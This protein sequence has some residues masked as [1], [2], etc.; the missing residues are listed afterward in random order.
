[1]FG[2]WGSNDA[3]TLNLT[4]NAW[5]QLN[6]TGTKPSGR[7]GSSSILYNKQMVMFGGRGSN[8]DFNDVWTLNLTSYAWTQL[9]TTGT[10]PSERYGHSSTLYNGQMVVFG[11]FNGNMNAWT[12]DLTAPT[13]APTTTLAPTT[14]Q[15]PTTK[16][17]QTTT[18]QPTTEID[19][20]TRASFSFVT[21]LLVCVVAI[22]V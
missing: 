10:K 6:T 2:G 12:L 3:W 20:S 16:Q 7:W 22:F 13:A 11:G 4:S 21:L 8:S 5:T 15:E 18:T 17:Q 9:N 19:G 1:M 14:T